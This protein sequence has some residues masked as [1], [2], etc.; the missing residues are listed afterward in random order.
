MSVTIRTEL[1]DQTSK[2]FSAES[3]ATARTPISTPP[4]TSN[5][6]GEIPNYAPAR[7]GR[8]SKY[9][10]SSDIW[11]GRSNTVGRS[12]TARL[13]RSSTGVGQGEEFGQVSY[14]SRFLATIS[15][16]HLSLFAAAR[17]LQKYLFLLCFRPPGVQCKSNENEIPCQGATTWVNVWD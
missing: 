14:L 8:K 12:P 7:T 11:Y 2:R 5:T 16:S 3:V 10:F 15:Q 1:T 17:P 13:V 9:C 4:L 6:D